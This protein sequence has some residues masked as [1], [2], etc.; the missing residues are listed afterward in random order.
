M[1]ALSVGYM[2]LAI[3]GGPRTVEMAQQVVHQIVSELVPGCL[4]A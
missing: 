4:T 2:L 3:E 1:T